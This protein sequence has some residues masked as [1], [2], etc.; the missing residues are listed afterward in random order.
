MLV[1]RKRVIAA[2]KAAALEDGELFELTS[3]VAEKDDGHLGDVIRVKIACGE[4]FSLC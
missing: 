1:C 4:T 2:S 3:L